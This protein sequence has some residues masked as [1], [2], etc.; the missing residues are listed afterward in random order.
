MI[1]ITMERDGASRSVELPGGDF[2]L[3]A[4]RWSEAVDAVAGHLA[5]VN[6]IMRHWKASELA[7]QAVEALAFH[8]P[9]LFVEQGRSSVGGPV[10]A[11]TPAERRRAVATRAVD[12]VDAM[13]E[14]LGPQC[15]AVSSAGVRCVLDLG[16]TELCDVR[17]WPV[18]EVD[19]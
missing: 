5:G 4:C 10:T 14:S 17:P 13:L 6:G 1:R 7:D 16:H 12:L 18:K 8:A 11:F 9:D 19:R 3:V 15:E 2:L